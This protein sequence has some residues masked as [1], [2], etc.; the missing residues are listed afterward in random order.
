MR[1]VV[2][3]VVQGPVNGCG[4]ADDVARYWAEG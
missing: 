4:D 3:E 1:I 2:E